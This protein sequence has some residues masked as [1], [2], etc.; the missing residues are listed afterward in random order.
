ML[1][2]LDSTQPVQSAR[3]TF[4]VKRCERCRS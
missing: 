1:L 2:E 4:G 3:V